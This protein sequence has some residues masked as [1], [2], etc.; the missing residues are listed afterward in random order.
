MGVARTEK[1]R[2]ED[3]Q[4]EYES[5]WLVSL[6]NM[7]ANATR[8]SMGHKCE[9]VLCSRNGTETYSGLASFVSEA[10]QQLVQ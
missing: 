4:A 3:K 10:S 1:G 7:L 6:G 2:R 5:H 9:T 8:R